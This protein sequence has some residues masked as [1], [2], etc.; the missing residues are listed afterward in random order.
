M[1]AALGWFFD[2]YVITIYA[3]TVP[4][5]AREFNVSTTLLSGAIGS[6]FLVGYAIGTI[7][8]GHSGDRFGRKTILGISIAGYGLTTALTG[9]SGGLV[10][11][12]VL[13]FLTGVAGGSELTIGAPY[14]SETWERN[15]RSS[16]IGFMYSFYP[17]GFVFGVAVFTLISPV[18]GWRA[19]YAVSIIP[20]IFVLIFRVRLEESPRFS[21]LV[22]VIEK[23]HDRQVSVLRAF[24]NRVFRFRILTGFLI[25]VSLTYGYYAMVF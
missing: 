20:A 10:M 17:L 16:G 19:V 5:I 9:F 6:T 15:R 23:G 24:A 21:A 18:W 1:A 25:F 8:F 3:L 7:G 11:L 13:R 2:A 22:D 14:V 12:G 4:Q